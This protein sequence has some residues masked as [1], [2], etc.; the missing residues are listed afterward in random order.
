MVLQQHQQKQQISAFASS[1]AYL[2]LLS[3]KALPMKKAGTPSKPTKL[4]RGVRQRHWGK[5]VLRLDSPGTEHVFGLVHLTPLKKLLWLMIKPHVKLRGDF[6][7]L[8]FTPS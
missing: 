7:C 8:N 4:Y 2:K 1:A 6:A 5:W 3:T